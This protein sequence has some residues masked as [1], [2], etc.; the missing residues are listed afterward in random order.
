MS[1]CSVEHQIVITLNKGIVTV[2]VHLV[3]YRDFFKRF[4]LGLKYAFGYK[5]KYGDWDE[6]VLDETHIE[7]LEEVIAYLKGKI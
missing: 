5:S 7:Q 3:T 6:I 1:C 2:Q 4:W